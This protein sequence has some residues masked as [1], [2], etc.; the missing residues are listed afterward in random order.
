MSTKKQLFSTLLILIGGVLLVYT[1]I[2]E[3][4]SVYFKIVGIIFLMIGLFRATR[5][6]VDDNKKDEF[7]E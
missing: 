3:Q 7:N 2:N 6:W 4:S 1:M 5:V